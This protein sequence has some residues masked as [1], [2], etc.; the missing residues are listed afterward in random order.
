MSNLALA[1]RSR[2]HEIRMLG[3]GT[4]ALFVMSWTALITWLSSQPGRKDD[5]SGL[6]TH[7]LFNAGH[8]PLY[9]FWA[10]GVAFLLASRVPRPAP[11]LLHSSLAVLAAAAYGTVDEIHQAFVPFRTAS[12]TDVVTD[13]FGA[14]VALFCLHY[15]GSARSTT[16]GIALRIL[17]GLLCMLAAGALATWIDN[18][19]G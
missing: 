16:A 13:A 10:A 8:A 7:V 6:A 18:I 4:L 19:S 14:A 15:I 2:A 5:P 17:G 9:G 11:G 12:W 3:A 1:F